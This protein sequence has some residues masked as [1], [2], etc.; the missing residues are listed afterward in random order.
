VETN[1]NITDNKFSP[2]LTKYYI[3]VKIVGVM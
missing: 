3:G 1:I 2:F